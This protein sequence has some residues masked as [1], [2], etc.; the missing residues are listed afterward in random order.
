MKSH[1]S[2]AHSIGICWLLVAADA[3]S[4]TPT[5]FTHRVRDAYVNSSPT[6]E[7]A[8]LKL[9]LDKT[10]AEYG[11]YEL[12]PAPQ[13]NVSRSLQSIKANTFPNYFASLGYNE[14][15]GSPDEISYIRFP[16]DLG[17]L[18]YR[19]CFAPQSSLEQLAKINTLDELRKLTIGQGR[20]WV[21]GSILKHNGFNV[22]EVEPYSVLFKMVAAHRLDLFCRGANE[23][24]EEFE[25]WGTTEGLGYDRHLLIYYPMPIFF[26]TNSQNK[27]AIARVTKGLK[28][29]YKDGSL[30]ALWRTQHQASVDFAEL[31]KRKVFRL[32]NPLVKSVDFDYSKYFYHVNI[33][34]KASHQ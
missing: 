17:L 13:I 20:G 9:A 12:K 23:I 18:S 25:Q 21:D 8:L 34:R 11:P 26:Y 28:K 31:D 14:S 33:N 6:Y 30:L 16:I 1:N 24:K 19:T 32:D 29:A 4:A 5:V 3:L 10:V 2:L 15:Y 27:E 7:T 22:V